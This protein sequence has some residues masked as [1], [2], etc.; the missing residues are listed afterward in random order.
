MVDDLSG[1]RGGGINVVEVGVFGVGDVVIDVD[2]GGG[3]RCGV[4]GV[5]AESGFGGA[6]E[7]DGDLD[8]D[9]LGGRGLNFI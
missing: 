6:V 2:P 4:K 1:R 3:L 5:F 9:W 7:C 8:V